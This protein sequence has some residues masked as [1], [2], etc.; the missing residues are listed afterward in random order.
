M[1]QDGREMVWGTFFGETREDVRTASFEY[2]EM[3]AL[4]PDRE[5]PEH[6]HTGAHFIFVVRGTYITEASNRPGACGART[7][8]FNPAHPAS[9]CAAAGWI[10]SG[11]CSR[12]PTFH[13]RSSRSRPASAIRVS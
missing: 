6:T 7:L 10:E 3:I 13:S 2:S 1:R 4:V 9:T 5:V 12:H 8:I 11:N